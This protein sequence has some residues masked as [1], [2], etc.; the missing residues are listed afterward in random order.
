M[1]RLRLGTSA[2]LIRYAQSTL[3]LTYGA[4]MSAQF[5]VLDI[6]VKLPERQVAMLGRVLEGE[7]VAGMSAELPRSRIKAR[8]QKVD[9]M[10]P[11]SERARSEFV[12]V[13]QM[14]DRSETEAWTE[15]L[16]RGVVLKITGKGPRYVCPCCGHRTLEEEPRGTYEICPVC[17]WEDDPVQ[18]ENPD[19]PGGANRV[20]LRTARQNYARIG[21][22]DPRFK[23]FVRLPRQDEIASGGEAAG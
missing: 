14:A 23:G 5:E 6:E 7:V 9:S 21:V 17:Y 15:E 4:K 1:P 19:Y 22:S 8:I 13:V 3:L 11:F 2:M 20:S 16:G 18:K 10:N 12:L